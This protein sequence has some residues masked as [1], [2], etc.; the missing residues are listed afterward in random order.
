MD[1]ITGHS[2]RPVEQTLLCDQCPKK[3]IRED[4]LRRH[5]K[6]VHQTISSKFVCNGCGLYSKR[7]YDLK[8]HKR[9]CKRKIEKVKKYS[10]RA[11]G[12]V[13]GICEQKFKWR[14]NLKRHTK[15]KHRIQAA[16]GSFMLLTA[17]KDSRLKPKYKKVEYICYR[18]P[19]LKSFYSKASLKRHKKNIP[20]R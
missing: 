2:G 13:C 6:E 17:S 16:N 5:V 10:L 7:K 9:T 1:P 18:C 15:L 12:A 8:I 11:T 4:N 20:Y 19:L 14:A 3:F